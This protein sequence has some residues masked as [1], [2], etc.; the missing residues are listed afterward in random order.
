MKKK[1]W[2]II[3]FIELIAFFIVYISF[4]K[5]DLQDGDIVFH[6][7]KSSQ[8]KAI[9][10]ATN[11]IYSHVGIVYIKNN[12]V[13]ILEAIQPVKLTPI[14]AWIKRGQNNKYVVKRLKNSEKILT[15]Q[16]KNRIKEEGNKFLGK[17]Y[18]L[19]FEWSDDRIYCSELVWKIYKRALGIEIGKLQKL[20]DFNLTSPEVQQK[21]KERY[22]SDIPVDETFISP[23]AIFESDLLE[24]IVDQK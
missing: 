17:D 10:K 20:S 7:S 16:A 22:G 6:T 11:S 24:T 4:K 12:K 21:M 9:Q 15:N 8:S 23:A 1:I 18:D 19:F 14:E 2:L 13:Y 3:H 5:D